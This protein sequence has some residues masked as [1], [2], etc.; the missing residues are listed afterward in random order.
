MKSRSSKRENCAVTSPRERME[1]RL[2]AESV[3]DEC[4][5]LIWRGCIGRCGYPRF[6]FLGRQIRRRGVYEYLHGVTLPAN[7]WVTSKCGNPLCVSK[8]CMVAM[9]SAELQR[10]RMSKPKAADVVARMTMARRK[11]GTKLS[12][13]AAREIRARADAG[14]TQDK[15]AAAFGVC[16]RTISCVV[17]HVIWREASPWA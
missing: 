7:W 10:M 12:L 4:G 9:P 1:R 16:K 14:E 3:E 8:E 15:L 17:R 5:C 13:Q 11:R 6:R 2:R